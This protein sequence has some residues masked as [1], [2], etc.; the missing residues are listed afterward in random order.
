[1]TLVMEPT[2]EIKLTILENELQTLINTRWLLERRYAV[3]KRLGQTGEELKAITE[4]L[5]KVEGLI[6]EWEKEKAEL[7]K[8]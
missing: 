3:G 4:D 1:M 6:S 5:V 8:P 7:E 2:K